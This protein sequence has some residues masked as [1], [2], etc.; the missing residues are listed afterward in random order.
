MILKSITIYTDGSCHTQ[1]KIGAWA[2]VILVDGKKKI[3]TGTVTNTTHQ[4]MELMAAINALENVQ[5]AYPSANQIEI[6]S[7]SQ[8]V[9]DLPARLEKLSAANYQS[10]QGKPI[11]NAALVQMFHQLI[12]DKPITFTKVKAHLKK[13]GSNDY[14]IEVDKLCRKLVRERVN[15]IIAS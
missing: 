9:V 7:D 11:Q 6:I 2:A 8:Y 15:G 12:K 5:E 4:I 14:N 10:K 3:L 13:T 1:L